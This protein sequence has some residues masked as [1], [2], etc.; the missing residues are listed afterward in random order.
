MGDGGEGAWDGGEESWED[1]GAWGGGWKGCKYAGSGPR[2]PGWLPEPPWAGGGADG[3]QLTEWD[4]SCFF[5]LL[6]IFDHYL[7]QRDAASA[8]D[9]EVQLSPTQRRRGRRGSICT[10]PLVPG[11]A[12]F[13]KSTLEWCG[14]PPLG[15]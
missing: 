11:K 9:Y 4:T 1:E 15:L 2:R 12:V 10:P 7:R 5:W 3:G 6:R 13:L 8:A 14:R